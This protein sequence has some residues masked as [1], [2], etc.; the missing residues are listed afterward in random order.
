MPSMRGDHDHRITQCCCSVAC[1]SREHL[2]ERFK[3]R[4]DALVVSDGK[5]STVVSVNI[6]LVNDQLPCI[7][8]RARSSNNALFTTVLDGL[9]RGSFARRASLAWKAI[10]VPAPHRKRRGL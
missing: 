9:D 2:A 7:E 4:W 6:L 10:D 1:E 3:F 8:W 5:W